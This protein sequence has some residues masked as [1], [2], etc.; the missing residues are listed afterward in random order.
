MLAVANTSNKELLNDNKEKKISC[1]LM[2][3]CLF[4]HYF[5]IQLVNCP[6]RLWSTVCTRFDVLWSLSQNNPLFTNDSYFDFENK[7]RPRL[8]KTVCM[9]VCVCVCGHVYVVYEDTNLYNNMGM[10]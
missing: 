7:K 3:H 8:P 6:F 10:T 1:E 4:Y 9:C 5:A 2:Q